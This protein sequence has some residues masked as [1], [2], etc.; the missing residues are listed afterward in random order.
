[1]VIY[2]LLHVVAEVVTGVKTSFV[3]TQS[4]TIAYQVGYL[5]YSLVRQQVYETILR[6]FLL[7]LLLLLL[8][9]SIRN[10]KLTRRYN[11]SITHKV[12]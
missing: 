11:G 2:L 5:S 9:I 4:T 1:M 7:I 8:F 10:Q 3:P 12:G 6:G